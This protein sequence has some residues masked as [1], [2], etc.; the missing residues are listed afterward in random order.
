[1]A[2]NKPNSGSYEEILRQKASAQKSNGFRKTYS[3]YIILIIMLILSFYVRKVTYD[4]VQN[5]NRIAFDKVTNSVIS[6]VSDKY[7][8][9]LHVLTSTSGLYD[10]YVEVVRDYFKLYSKVPTSSDP[11][12]RSMMYIQPV[13]KGAVSEHIFN[14]QRQ[15]LF[16]Y[17]IH[18]MKD[19]AL[20]YPV[21]F[22]E[23]Q[24]KF[25]KNAGFDFSSEANLQKAIEKARDNN[26][27]VATMNIK[28]LNKNSDGT[29]FYLIAPVYKMNA[30]R[31]NVEERQHNFNGVV[32]E[33][34]GLEAF[35]KD[36]LAG[37][38]PSDKTVL[39]EFT[40]VDS[41]ANEIS[42]IFHSDNY[43]E[44]AEQKYNRLEDKI[45]IQVADKKFVGHFATVP[46]FNS[47]I[48][49]N[50]HNITF[51]IALLLSFA[52]FGFVYSVM[53]GRARAEHLA[54]KMTRS[55]RMI[56]E[57]AKD[58]IAV[59]DFNGQWR[60]LNPAVATVFGI[61]P[62]DML[63][64][65]FNDY[66][67]NES[68]KSDFNEKI[69]TTRK[70]DE[71]VRCDYQM[72]AADGTMKWVSWSF[73]VSQEDQLVYAIGRDITLEK[74]AEERAILQAKQ[75]QLAEQYT[76][77]SSEF[78][79]YFMRKLSHQMRNS[80]T[81]I[82]GY[83]QMVEIK[84]YDTEEEEESYIKLAEES[85]NELF[86]F[87]SDIVEVASTGEGNEKVDIQTL[88]V[89]DVFEDVKKQFSKNNKEIG[90]KI[91]NLDEDPNSKPKVIADRNFLE[92][93]L[94]GIFNAVAQNS[95]EL[96]LQ[97]AATENPYEGATEIQMMTNGNA[98][99]S[100]MIGIFKS[101][102]KNLINNLSKDKNDVMLNLAIASSLIRMMNGTMTVDTF[103]PEEGNVI[104]ITLPLN[105]KVS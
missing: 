101:N 104:Q 87:L 20:Y 28:T 48:T 80:L 16:D 95:K 62:N 25:E 10:K 53:T 92:K 24:E 68:D 76:R 46:T 72:K 26:E 88:H 96:D 27:V 82:L 75:T 52:L 79:S 38:F 51:I 32:V 36:A 9:N 5:D 65:S 81:G 23:P 50:L 100:E 86:S 99:V 55:Q 60:S 89:N 103:G 63:A 13:T 74:E 34:I 22:I 18:P 57:N 77:E 64:K 44:F 105:K 21:A 37:N 41:T 102:D 90:I 14:M 94:N 29:G 56:T 17:T 98:L 42:A 15:G 97:V 6:R 66:L 2:T 33:E 91:T 93:A 31:S 11:S 61:A 69:K 39:F 49:A 54:E 7:H 73:A 30:P 3:A 58:I 67:L 19:K 47:K 78:K 1:M 8:S 45:E 40:E 12:I 70:V 59:I 85:G 71:T 35:F 4:V 43:Q 84:A 83:L